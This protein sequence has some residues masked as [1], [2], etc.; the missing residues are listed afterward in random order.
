MDDFISAKDEMNIINRFA[1]I[2]FCGLISHQ[3]WVGKNPIFTF[4]LTQLS[5]RDGQTDQL[6]R[7]RSRCACC[8]YVR[9]L[10]LRYISFYAAFRSLNAAMHQCLALSIACLTFI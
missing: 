1:V 4:P 7:V 10:L 8:V 5:R 3:W 2:L 9:S 6:Y